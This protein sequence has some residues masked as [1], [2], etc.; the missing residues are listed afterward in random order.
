MC[1]REVCLASPT[2]YNSVEKQLE[3]NGS[4]LGKAEMRKSMGDFSESFALT[5]HELLGLVRSAR[6]IA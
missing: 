4:R 1:A 3:N 2:G 6:A 5:N